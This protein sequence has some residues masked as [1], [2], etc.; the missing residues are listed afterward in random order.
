MS[1]L[2]VS[3]SRSERSVS[4]ISR[5]VSFILRSGESNRPACQAANAVISPSESSEMIA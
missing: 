3:V 1:S 4:L 5:A 2:P